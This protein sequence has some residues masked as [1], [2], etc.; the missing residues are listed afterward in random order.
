MKTHVLIGTNIQTAKELLT[1]GK[2]VGIPTETVYGLAANAL[3]PDAV[4]EIYRVKKR[5]HFDPMIIHLPH[6]DHV[7][8][9]VEE[10]HPKFELLAKELGPGPITFLL[11]RKSIIPD[12]VTSGSDLVAVRIPKHPMAV[13]LLESLDFPLAAPSANP[14]G[15][16]SPTCARHV[17]DQLGDKIPY[18]LDGGPCEV[19]IESTIVG[20]M[21][22]IPTI[23]RKGGYSIEKIND[24]CGKMLIHPSSSSNPK[25]PGMLTNHYAPNKHFILGS[26]DLLLQKYKGKK[27]G[28]ITFNQSYPD[29][30]NIVEK[31]LSKTGDLKEAARNLFSVM[32]EMDKENIDVILAEELPEEGLGVAINDRLR[33]ASVDIDN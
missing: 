3:D 18:I 29:Q 4:L 19:G 32:R 11:K 14:F 1:A 6:W 7:L 15:Y 25:A 24:V 21:G 31:S 9:Y 20:M 5:P 26:L 16:I 28:L 33:R 17:E 30:V 8:K 10:I 2:L 13:N 23:Y 22:N 12:I 27:I